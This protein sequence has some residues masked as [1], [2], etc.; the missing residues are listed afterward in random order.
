METAALH[1]TTSPAEERSRRGWKSIEGLEELLVK[2][3]IEP[4]WL[5][6]ERQR[7]W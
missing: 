3:G 4:R 5:S 6:G 1:N 7:Q 2:E